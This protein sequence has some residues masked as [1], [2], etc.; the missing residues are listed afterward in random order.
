[1]TRKTKKFD[2]D[3]SG[4]SCQKKETD[5]HLFQ[6]ILDLGDVYIYSYHDTKSLLIFVLSEYQNCCPYT[7]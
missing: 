4:L 5:S 6:K 2:P 3:L 7:F 1:M